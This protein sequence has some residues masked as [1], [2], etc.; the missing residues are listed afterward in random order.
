[1]P[2]T[3]EEN[4]GKGAANF[5]SLNKECCSTRRTPHK[6]RALHNKGIKYGICS[7]KNAAM[8]NAIIIGDHT[9]G[10]RAYEENVPIFSRTD[11]KMINVQSLREEKERGGKIPL[12]KAICFIS[13]ARTRQ[14]AKVQ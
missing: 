10:A 7:R 4:L 5:S 2:I 12:Q 8:M 14:K 11:R 9:D 3:G 1:M 13:A 6:F